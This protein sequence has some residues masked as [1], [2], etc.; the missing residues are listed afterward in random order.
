MAPI[1]QEVPAD[2]ITLTGTAPDGT[3]AVTAGAVAATL[4]TDRRFWARNVP[5]TPGENL[6]PV[7]ATGQDGRELQ[8]ETVAVVAIPGPDPVQ[9]TLDPPSGPPPLVVRLRVVSPHDLDE[10]QI[11]FDGDGRIDATAAAGSD[12]EHTYPTAGRY[13]P[14]ATVRT[15][16]GLWFSSLRASPVA[17]DPLVLVVPEPSVAGSAAVDRPERVLATADGK[18]LVLS[19]GAREVVV[20]DQ[21]LA[22]RTRIPLRGVDDPSGL[23]V[24][25]GGRYL[26]CDAARHRLVRLLRTGALDLTFAFQG[27][28]GEAGIEPLQFQRPSDVVLDD[29]GNIYVA[30]TGNRRIQKLNQEGVFEAQFPLAGE[31]VRL[32]HLNGGLHYALAGSEELAVLNVLGVERRRF[33]ASGRGQV[34]SLAVL[35]ARGWLATATT[36]EPTIWLQGL[37]GRS[38]RALRLPEVTGVEHVALSAR[39]DRLELV[40]GDASGRVLRVLVP[41]DDAAAGAEGVV[42]TMLAKLAAGDHEG[43]LALFDP[44]VRDG[45]RRQFAALTPELRASLPAR[46]HVGSVV[47][48]SEQH[49][50][51]AVVADVGGQTQADVVGLS[52][53]PVTFAWRVVVF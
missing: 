45:Y 53:D 30:D 52:R 40:V 49:A 47:E 26:V 16:A 39:A 34:R 10:V 37:D 28:V 42:T 24:D 4:E 13:P 15:R 19:R 18:F 43:A 9:L 22:V 48:Q 23:A 51:V 11:D 41:E 36:D 7:V 50:D 33:A 5:L 38:R 44:E 8:R 17:P 35:A 29:E 21:E 27:F 31:P 3:T 2:R 25:A 1:Q 32:A 6:I 20:L 12:V 46:I 14:Q